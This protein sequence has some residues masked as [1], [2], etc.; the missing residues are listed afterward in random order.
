MKKILRLVILIAIFTLVIGN[1]QA[2]ATHLMG[3]D[4][5][6]KCLDN[7]TF[8]ITLVVYRRCT[9]GAVSLSIYPPTITSD[10]C[11]NAHTYPPPSLIEHLV[12]EITPLCGTVPKLCPSAGG[13]GMSSSQIP[14]GVERHTMKY[15]IYLGGNYANCCWYKLSWEQ[16]ARNSNITTGY[17]DQDFITESWLNR[18]VAP[19][20]N[21]PVFINPPIII[22]CAGQ[23]VYYNHGV[24]EVDG[25]SLTYAMALPLGGGVFTAP[26]SYTYPL[27]CLGGNNPNPNAIP[28]TGFNLNP[29]NG[30]ISFRPMVVQITVLKIMVTEWRKDSTGKYKV[31]G[32]TARD[33]QF[34][35]VGNCNNKLPT[36]SGPFTYGVC[37]GEQICITVNTNDLDVA[38]TS[39]IY[40]NGGIKNGSW[41]SNND[42]V[43]NATGTMCWTPSNSDTSSIPYYFSVTADDNR[44]PLL[45]TTI[46]SFAI[47]VS[48]KP[49]NTR[50]YNKITC[51]FF[52]FK[53]IPNN[54]LLNSSTYEWYVPKLIGTGLP[55]TVLSNNAVCYYLFTQAGT[56]L[57]RN[58]M[59]FK[60]CTNTYFDTLIVD[61][62]IQHIITN[63]NAILCP[64]ETIVLTADSSSGYQWYKD[65]SAITGA[66]SRTYTAIE[67]GQYSV[68][69]NS[70]G[71]ILISNTITISEISKLKIN[72]SASMCI[73]DTITYTA[74]G[75]TGA[76]FQW[77]FNG[78]LISG[79]TSD[80]LFA[81]QDGIYYCIITQPS[82]I[83]QSNSDTAVF[84]VLPTK[85]TI[86]KF[87]TTL[88][89]SAAYQYQWYSGNTIING[90]TNISYSP[91]T[92]GVYKVKVMGVNGC[93]IF[94]DP[95]NYTVGIN[96][97]A[98]SSKIKISPNPFHNQLTLEIKDYDKPILIS[99]YDMQ[100][101]LILQQAPAKGFAVLNTAA[102]SLGLY[103]LEITDGENKACYK[104]E[105]E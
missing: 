43:K 75:K 80:K 87:N 60:G 4:M 76:T 56:Y 64:G 66:N 34:A 95:Y 51:S 105:K 11:A 84:L 103:L 8:E 88:A 10:S 91:P 33:M 89:S 48:P 57:I 99:L 49:E 1:K 31:I 69:N 7:D 100:G 25:D 90:A 5:Q 94:S 81:T 41:T 65:T 54:A 58:V 40:W 47:T 13:T 82:C 6:W 55:A 37:S 85:P 30:D 92:A 20:D 67:A 32:K 15:K 19:C 23:D 36:L 78:S 96:S 97:N 102:L 52:E 35:I 71:C 44:C 68:G 28:P 9:D 70:A 38:D 77:Y 29:G 61:S 14:F 26:W 93:W 12:A 46:H 2:N 72:K 17:G 21:G 86:T 74:I 98:L 18:C 27:T 24:V 53:A 73:G 3:A 39:R 22:K 79:S 59:T 62:N 63:G 101:K 50:S 104:V 42:S 16:S 45:G 83:V